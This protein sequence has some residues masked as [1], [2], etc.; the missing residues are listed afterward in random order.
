MQ[1]QKQQS[2]SSKVNVPHNIPGGGSYIPIC[3]QGS[4][5]GNAAS[6]PSYSSSRNVH[7][8]PSHMMAWNHGNGGGGRNNTKKGPG[9]GYG[10]GRPRVCAR[11]HKPI[12]NIALSRMPVAMT[13]AFCRCEDD[14]Q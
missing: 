9:R 5:S 6:S 2:K 12:M 7:G 10:D 11:C 8:T 4:S 13:G 1:S 14:A 3:N